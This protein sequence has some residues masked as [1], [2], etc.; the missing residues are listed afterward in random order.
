MARFDRFYT[1][2]EKEC[3]S[4][5]IREMYVGISRHKRWI[6]VILPWLEMVPT[7]GSV[8]RGTLGS[9]TIDESVEGEGI[10]VE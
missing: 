2:L 7:K 3:V 1:D 4:S 9:K 8:P 10:F 5:K 6:P